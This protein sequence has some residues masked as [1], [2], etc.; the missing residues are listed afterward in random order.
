MALKVHLVVI[1]PQNDFMGNDD[2]SPYAVQ[3]GSAVQQASLPV[4]GAV[5][6]MHRLA[7]MID[8]VGSR[9]EDIHVTLDSHRVI[10]VA[11]PGMWRDSNGNHPPPFTFIT[12]ADIDNGTWAPVDPGLRARL[13]KYVVELKATGN[14]D[15]C[16]WPEHC[17]IG[18]WG[19]NVQV[20]LAQALQRWERTYFANV[21]YVAKGTNVYTEHYGALQ[22][23]VPD[24]NDPS[25]QLNAG[26]LQILQDA[27]IVG[28][29]GEASS[30][31]VLETVRQIAVNIGVEHVKKFQLIMDCMSP[32]IHPA[33]DFPKIARDFFAGMEQ[34]GMTLTDSARFLGN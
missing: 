3:A 17:L 33:V 9:L 14:K 29:A 26:F 5:S 10:D 13:K 32:V 21:D 7:A 20:D 34:Q 28:V 25:T 11:N 2:G 31:C 22:A 6:D 18:S 24:P 16:I 8:R 12:E 30:H 4:P 27:D 15:L 1:D 19:H 23:E